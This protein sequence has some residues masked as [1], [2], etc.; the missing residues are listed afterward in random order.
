MIGSNYLGYCLSTRFFR[1]LGFDFLVLL[2]LSWGLHGLL[3]F[4]DAG[5][6]SL[7]FA[8]ACAS[9]VQSGLFLGGF[10]DRNAPSGSSRPKALFVAIW[11]ISGVGFPLQQSL[12][13]NGADP[14]RSLMG[15]YGFLAPCCFLAFVLGRVASARFLN[16]AI[17]LRAINDRAFNVALAILFIVPG[18]PLFAAIALLIYLVDGRPV[19]YKGRRLGLRKRPFTMYKF[20]TLT[21][22]ADRIIGA[23]ILS[24][25]NNVTIPLGGFLRDTRLD[26]LPQ[27]LNILRGDM[28][29]IGPRPLRPEQYEDL[30]QGIAKF[31]RLFG[32]RPGL[33][34]YS[35]LF[36]PHA[37]PKRLRSLI[38][39]R[40]MQRR[41]SSFRQMR[42]IGFTVLTVAAKSAGRTLKQVQEVF[43]RTAVRGRRRRELT[44]VRPR[45]ALAFID[46]NRN[47]SYEGRGKLLDMNDAAFRI[48]CPEPIASE[49]VRLKLEIRVRRWN[50]ASKDPRKGRERTRSARCAGRVCQVRQRARYW[51]YV[52][53]Y[54]PETPLSHYIV[55][56]YFL[57]RSLADPFSSPRPA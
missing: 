38:D 40:E 3:V 25:Q 54:Q 43:R 9:A 7:G 49:E 52:I 50:G 30:C 14:L 33:I 56:Q 5:A 8:L 51:D 45:G 10:Y 4:P 31:D 34:G 55:Q 41:P 39:S 42:I 16:G 32:V 18:L 22:G 28:N 1:R 36:T 13:L 53:A 19:I 46:S 23:K 44:R 11:L 2:S 57:R 27:L 6:P 12:G 15:L 24:H 17:D 35:Q 26:E 48:R 37:S 47:G 29:F 20:R 21:L